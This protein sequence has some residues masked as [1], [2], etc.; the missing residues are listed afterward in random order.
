MA[1]PMI[2]YAAVLAHRIYYGYQP[3]PILGPILGVPEIPG[4]KD[5]RD[6]R[7]DRLRKEYDQRLESQRD[8]TDKS[9]RTFKT[10]ANYS[11]MSVETAKDDTSQSRVGRSLTSK[12]MTRGKLKPSTKKF[13]SGTTPYA[14][15]PK[16]DE[17]CRKGYKSV[18]TSGRRMCVKID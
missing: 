18:M 6:R 1:I 13:L 16:S 8:S 3:V 7:D 9:W 2:A 14:Y 11:S 12:P 4:I 10:P 5:V 17:R 15:K